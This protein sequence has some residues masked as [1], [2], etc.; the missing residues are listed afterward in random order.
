M[1]KA[2]SARKGEHS[3][4]G[5]VST[6]NPHRMGMRKRGPY[7]SLKPDHCSSREWPYSVA[8]RS[9]LAHQ[10]QNSLQ[11][12]KSYMAKRGQGDLYTQILF[13]LQEP[14]ESL[15]NQKP[16]NKCKTFLDFN[17]LL[18]TRSCLIPPTKTKTRRSQNIPLWEYPTLE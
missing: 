11:S 14:L 18:S 8:F 15:E 4:E 9:H 7:P 5:S 2:P 3:R 1:L 16:N 10:K 17:L 12:L 13:S 6:F